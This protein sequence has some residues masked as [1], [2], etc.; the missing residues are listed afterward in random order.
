MMKEN[1]NDKATAV[2]HV[3]CGWVISVV[4]EHHLE[5]DTKLYLCRVPRRNPVD[6]RRR[7]HQ[8]IVVH[9]WL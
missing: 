6:W 2:S 4:K 9:T 3:A 8:T 7:H 5:A 1:R